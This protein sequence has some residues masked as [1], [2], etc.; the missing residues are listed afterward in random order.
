[1]LINTDLL[2]EVW[3]AIDQI[4]EKTLEAMDATG[5]SFEAYIEGNTTCLQIMFMDHSLWS[6]EENDSETMNM[7]VEDALQELSSVV[8]GIKAIEV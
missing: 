1:M 2:Q 7:I 6:T 3:H 8:T 5:Q 4:N